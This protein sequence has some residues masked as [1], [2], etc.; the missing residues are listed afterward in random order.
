MKNVENLKQEL[1]LI[2]LE[3]RLEM[4]AL[5]AT[6]ASEGNNNVCCCND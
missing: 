2:V 5:V 1:D 4:V 3:E 6:V